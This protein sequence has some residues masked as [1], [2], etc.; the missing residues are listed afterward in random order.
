VHS[1]GWKLIRLFHAG[2][3]GQHRWKLYHL[4][5]DQAE[6]NDL[7]E[8]HLDK[9]REL[10]QKIE[11]FLLRTKAV[12]PQ[13]NIRFNPTL[14]RIDLEGVPNSKTTNR[15]SKNQKNPR[16]T[17]MGWRPND[18]ANLLRNDQGMKIDCLGGDP[19]LIHD[20]SP[21]LPAGEYTAR[22]FFASTASGDAQWF[23]SQ[24]GRI[25]T[26]NKDYSA[27]FETRQDGMHRWH[28]FTFR[29]DKPITS[30]RLDPARA[31]GVVQLN[32]VEVINHEGTASYHW[33]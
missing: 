29:T 16:E 30:F 5:Q 24:Q 28:E 10:D 32:K 33:P 20:L 18:Q 13:K 25:P 7:S 26:F 8:S 31:K 3:E 2:N 17:V 14:Y 12:V 23:W 15:K 11:Q 19:Y 27:T 1:N 6:R 4:D 21:V 22:L 9:V